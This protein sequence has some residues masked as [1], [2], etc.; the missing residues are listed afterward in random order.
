MVDLP[1]AEVRAAHFP[2]APPAV[3]GE[4]EG[5]LAGTDQNANSTHGGRHMGRCA[6][7]QAPV[8]LSMTA[9]MPK[10]DRNGVAVH[11]ETEG[12]GSPVLLSHGFAATLR[13]WDPQ[14]AALADRHRLIRWDMRGH[15]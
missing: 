13:M 12:T 3:G 8:V 10:L 7:L 4:H 1:A 15:G 2:V 11:Y 6:T 5:A 14:V 9:R